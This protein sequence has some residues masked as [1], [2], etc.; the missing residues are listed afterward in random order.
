MIIKRL[1]GLTLSIAAT[2]TLSTAFISQAVATDIK[3]YPNGPI[4]LVVPF[5][6]G[7][8]SDTVGRLFGS[9]LSEKLGKPVIVENKS[10]ASGAI[11]AGIVANANPDGL[12]LLL[13]TYAR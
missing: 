12:T 8:G 6:P 13:S 10:G 11:G 5:P 3:N 2:L 1:A 4:R 7:G 9:K